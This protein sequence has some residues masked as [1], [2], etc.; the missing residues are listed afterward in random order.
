MRFATPGFSAG[1]KRTQFSEVSESVTALLNLRMM[2]SGFSMRWTQPLGSLSDLDILLVGSV[3]L[4]MR[5]P[6]RGM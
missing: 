2:S 5:A 6:T 4:M 1:S 3:R